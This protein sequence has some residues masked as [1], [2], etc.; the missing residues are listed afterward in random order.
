MSDDLQPYNSLAVGCEIPS[1]FPPHNSHSQMIR[2]GRDMVTTALSPPRATIF[3][4]AASSMGM[5]E[6]REWR[7]RAR[8][9]NRS[10]ALIAA[11][12]TGFGS[13]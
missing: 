3:V 6:S 1:R 12:V 9:A 5:T 10:S 4:H 8:W 2:P 13:G 11:S 7:T